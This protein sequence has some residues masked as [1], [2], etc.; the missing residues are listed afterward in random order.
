MNNN[1]IEAK[2]MLETLKAMD[3]KVGKAF[4]RK[5]LRAGAK[6]QQTS[7]KNNASSVT[8][9][10]KAALKIKATKRSTKRVGMLVMI[11]KGDFSNPKF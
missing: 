4:A 7:A 2:A 9:S 11:S 10:T 8:G 5:A 3:S 6:V 1:D